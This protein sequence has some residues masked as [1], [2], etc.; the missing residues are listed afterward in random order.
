MIPSGCGHGFKVVA[1]KS[2]SSFFLLSSFI[3]WLG[4]GPQVPVTPGQA[5]RVGRRPTL[6]AVPWV[7]G[8]ALV[9]ITGLAGSGLAGSGL[10][11]ATASG[12]PL[13]GCVPKSTAGWEGGSEIRGLHF[14]KLC[15]FCI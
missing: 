11:L 2:C 4:S 7:W 10:G 12:A 3:A 1:H 13:G 14:L 6:L 9:F 15:K 5:S 8:T